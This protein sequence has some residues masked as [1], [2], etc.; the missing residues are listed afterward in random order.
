MTI[1]ER[2]SLGNERAR[3]R[4]SFKYGYIPPDT[5]VIDPSLPFHVSL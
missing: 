5:L 4:H 1:V 2:P 3:R